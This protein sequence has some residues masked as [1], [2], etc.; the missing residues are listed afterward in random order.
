[1]NDNMIAIAAEALKITEEEAKKNS[2]PIPEI[3]AVYVW[4]PTRGGGAVIVASN[5][6]KLA[7]GS[8][9]NFDAHLQVFRDGTRN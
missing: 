8:S 5:G 2:K 6:E 4:N 3:E 7:A 9:V 1:M